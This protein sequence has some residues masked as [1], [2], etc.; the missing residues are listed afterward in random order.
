[1][2]DRKESNFNFLAGKQRDIV[3]IGIRY[4]ESVLKSAEALG[5]KLSWVPMI[6]PQGN[7]ISGTQTPVFDQFSSALI[8]CIAFWLFLHLH[9]FLHPKRQDIVGVS[10][11]VFIP[12]L[13]GFIK[14]C[15]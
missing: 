8:F 11:E 14:D 2:T 15:I 1:M 4:T 3:S 9:D 13:L 5:F 7:D 12:G 6:L 10:Q